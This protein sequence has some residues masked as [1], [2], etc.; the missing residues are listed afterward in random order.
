[1]SD[2]DGTTKP[3]QSMEA[4]P[5]AAVDLAAPGPVVIARRDGFV[6]CRDGATRSIG[7]ALTSSETRDLSVIRQLLV[8][9][10]IAAKPDRQVPGVRTTEPDLL[11]YIYRLCAAYHTTRATTPTLRRVRDR[12]NA[13]GDRR[14]A[15]SAE[16]K[17][18]E[19]T[20]HDILALRDLGAMGLPAADLV[21]RFAPQ[22][23]QAL[24]AVLTGL[25]REDRPYGVFG[26]AYFLE[27]LAL[28]RDKE[29]V[30]TMQ[31][32][33]PRGTDVTRC[34]RVH[35]AVGADV[36][37]VEELVELVAGLAPAE[38][39]L[40]C[41]GIYQSAIVMFDERDEVGEKAALEALLEEWGWQ[42]FVGVATASSTMGRKM[43]GT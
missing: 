8:G 7:L 29:H 30:D 13:L 15:N 1:M 27:R 22:H 35:S 16:Q 11:D 5:M 20:G 21:A 4:E 23:A 14:S 31:N 38:R 24:V 43:A 6:F 39:Q 37:H 17:A 40:V 19:E 25:S 10:I 18:V 3:V 9:C 41:R 42:P 2:W 34:W 28:L 26:Y 12:L 33:A 32:L 36:T